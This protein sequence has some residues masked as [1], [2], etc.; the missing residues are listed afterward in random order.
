M[1]PIPASESNISPTTSSLIA[2]A[3]GSTGKRS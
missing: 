2:R 1:E 3:D